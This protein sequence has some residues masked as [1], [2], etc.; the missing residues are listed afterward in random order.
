DLILYNGTVRTLNPAR[1]VAQALAIKDGLILDLGSNEEILGLANEYTR[2]IDLEGLTLMP[3]FVDPHTHLIFAGQRE[4][5]LPMKQSG[6]SYL[7]ILASG[8]GILNTVRATRNASR[9][10]LVMAA[11]AR[12]DR[13]L[14]FGTTTAEAK[15]GYG[16]DKDTELK[17]LEAIAELAKTH[18]VE[19]VPTFLGA[20]AVPEEYKGAPDD[21]IEFV[22]SDVLPEV[23]ARKL[24]EFCDI[25]CEKGVFSVDNSR[26]L[27]SAAQKAGLGLR[28]H[29]DEIVRLGG[30]ALAVELG[31]VSASHLMQT[32]DQE[33]EGMAER[34]VI[35]E[36]LPATPF[37][38]MEKE[39]PRARAMIEA[40][41]PVALST[42]LNP[43]CWTESM[44]FVIALAAYNMKL[45]PSEALAAATRNAAF[46]IN[47]ADTV[48]SLEVGKQADV[49][50][51]DAKNH[52]TIPYH[53]GVNLI[54]TVIK[55]GKIVLGEKNLP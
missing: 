13:M 50:V 47:R 9:E 12:L 7:E 37:A 22:I 55:K 14:A 51:L 54:E 53:F 25:F 29:S 15:S 8:G 11:T 6:A 24:A 46:A 20:H 36:L 28:I 5:E 43:N 23:A 40:G 10:E 16:L 39:Y 26:K 21:Y 31:A 4:F 42:D 38:L 3:G 18:T 33:F 1:P 2:V 44:Q 32:S 35:A 27:L 41:V 19:L 45:H 17:S 52:L 48:G 49:L 30:T 34:G